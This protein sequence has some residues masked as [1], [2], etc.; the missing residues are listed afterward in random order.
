M[1]ICNEL[2][3]TEGGITYADWYLP[4]ITEL[5]MIYEKKEKVVASANANGGNYFVAEYYWSSTEYNNS[6]AWQRSLSVD[7]ILSYSKDDAVGVRA[8]RKF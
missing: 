4:S 2:Q 5:K 8:V 1:R 3:I 7:H 6:Y